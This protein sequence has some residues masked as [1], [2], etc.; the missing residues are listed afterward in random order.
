MK[1]ADIEIGKDYAYAAWEGAARSQVTVIQFDAVKRDRF[2]N[3]QSRGTLV[4]EV[5][6]QKREFVVPNRELRCPWAEEAERRTS[7]ARQ[8]AQA[9]QWRRDARRQ[10]APQIKRLL[11]LFE[12]AGL[13]VETP[14][15]LPN[16]NA[17]STPEEAA[18]DAAEDGFH[19]FTDDRGWVYLLLPESLA[20]AYYNSDKIALS[21]D[22]L[23]GVIDA[24]VEDSD[25][26]RT[27]DL[28]GEPV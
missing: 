13:D 6:G 7:L 21:L 19:A 5:T 14:T 25:A 9:R 3:I 28:D 8:R 17:N 18:I 16:G 1:K 22:F 26:D 15:W 12:R 24:A 27:T 2:N 20:Y 4:R 10:K 11:D 23:L